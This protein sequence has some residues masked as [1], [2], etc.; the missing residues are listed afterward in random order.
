METHSIGILGPQWQRKGW[1]AGYTAAD[2]Y[3][4]YAY[5]YSPNEEAC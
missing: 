1:D 4:A 5:A 3:Y 2:L